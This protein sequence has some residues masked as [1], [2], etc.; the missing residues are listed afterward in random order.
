VELRRRRTRKTS[1]AAF[2]VTLIPLCAAGTLSVVRALN[3]MSDPPRP[4]PP[5]IPTPQP[6]L[7]RV[8]PLPGEPVVP[9]V[10][11]KQPDE[12]VPDANPEPPDH[13]RP[14]PKDLA[15]QSNPRRQALGLDPL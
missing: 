10:P 5:G 1:L 13:T 4:S 2:T 6:P 12:E 8:P 9:D 14:A 11:D 15:A 3:V 7:P